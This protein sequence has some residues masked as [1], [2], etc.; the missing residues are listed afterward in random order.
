YKPGSA[1]ARN[2]ADGRER[3][4][5]FCAENGIPHERCGKLVVAT[6]PGEL[7]A[8][9]ELE[10]RGAANGLTGIRRL[11]TDGLRE[12]EPHVRGVAGLFVPQ[13][14]IVDYVAVARAYAA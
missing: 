10:R 5:R 13:T 3:M 14:G 2:C 7:P 6:D 8:L 11:G 12:H 4:Y 1:K 9:D